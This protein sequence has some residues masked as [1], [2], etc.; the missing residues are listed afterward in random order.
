MKWAPLCD[1]NNECVRGGWGT[2]FLCSPPPPPPLPPSITAD[3]FLRK[4]LVYVTS[5][6]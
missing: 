6:K 1:P 2:A 4:L 5:K 3:F